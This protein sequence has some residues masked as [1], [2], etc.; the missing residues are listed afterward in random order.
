MSVTITTRQAAR[1]DEVLDNLVD[2]LRR[3]T[4]HEDL[5]MVTISLSEINAAIRQSGFELRR[6]E[7]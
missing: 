2:V 5:I 1:L 6:R 7:D 4:D 3:S